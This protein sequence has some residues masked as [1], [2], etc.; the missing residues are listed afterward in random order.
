MS[1]IAAE[2]RKDTNLRCYFKKDI[3]VDQADPILLKVID[4]TEL[5]LYKGTRL[6]IPT[7]FQSEI[8][9]CYHHYLIHPGHTRLEE[10][11]AA[12]MYWRSLRSDVRKHVK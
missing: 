7:S 2:Q 3:E 12:S 9:K 8:V 4:E 5:L 1:Q 6:V 11:I 10:T